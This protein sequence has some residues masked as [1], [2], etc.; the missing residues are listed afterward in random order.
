MLHS[1]IWCLFRIERYDSQILLGM[2]DLDLN[3]GPVIC[4]ETSVK[5]YQPTPRDIAVERSPQT[6]NIT[7][8]IISYS[9]EQGPSW[10]GS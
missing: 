8:T 9:M 5:K 7:Y 3:S 1:V 4:A 2:T 6:W 10:E